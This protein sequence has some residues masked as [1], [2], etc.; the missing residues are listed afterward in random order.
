MNKDELKNHQWVTVLDSRDDT[1][2]DCVVIS[3][4][5]RTFKVLYTGSGEFYADFIYG[6]E[7]STGGMFKL[8]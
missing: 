6:S 7:R 1:I 5:E 2:K 8:L 3:L 4:G